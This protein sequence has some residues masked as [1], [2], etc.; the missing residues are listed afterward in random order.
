M[1]TH[2]FLSFFLWSKRE[3][4]FPSYFLDHKYLSCHKS[5]KNLFLFVYFF[6]SKSIISCKKKSF[7]SV[8]TE[9]RARGTQ[10]PNPSFLRI[11]SPF[12]KNPP[13]SS[14]EA[15]SLRANCVLSFLPTE[16]FKR[17]IF[18]EKLFFCL[19]FRMV[20][21]GHSLCLSLPPHLPRLHLSPNLCLLFLRREILDTYTD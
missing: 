9:T 2:F 17:N 12:L 14:P 8:W 11:F 5:C 3:L 7:N 6:L 20:V 13:S 18:S 21:W 19:I 1:E 4:Q 10:K 15:E 16:L